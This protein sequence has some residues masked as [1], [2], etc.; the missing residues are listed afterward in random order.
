MQRLYYHETE[1]ALYFS[2]EAK[3]LLQAIP[4]LRQ[5]NPDSLAKHIT[6]DCVLGDKSLFKGISLLP[7][8]SCWTFGR[9]SRERTEKYFK[10]ESLESAPVIRHEDVVDQLERTFVDILP[11]YLEASERVAISLTGGL[12][13]R[14]IVAAAPDIRA[15]PA[16][17]FAGNRDTFDVR[18]SRRVAE[19]AGLNYEVI[20]L[21]TDF[22]DQ[23]PRLAEETIYISDGTFGVGGAHNLYL[24]R[25]ARKV[26]P[27]RLTGLF[28]SE[29]VRQGRIFSPAT[30]V[31]ALFDDGFLSTI[32]P[33][34]GRAIT[35]R[36]GHPL[37]AALFRD[38]PWRGHGSMSIERSQ[39]TLRSPFTDNDLTQLMYAIPGV[40][41]QS[42]RVQQRLIENRSREI[43]RILSNRGLASGRNPL[44]L[45]V[46]QTA[47]QVLFKADY[48]YFFDT[49]GWMLKSEPAIRLLKLPQLLL[50]Y[51]KFEHYRVWYRDNLS[52]YL[53]DTLLD[54]RTL[55]RPFFSRSG[56]RKA[57]DNHIAGKGNHRIELDVALSLELTMRTMIERN[58][59]VPQ[60]R[61][62]ELISQ[63]V[64]AAGLGTNR[65]A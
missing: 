55:E 16:Y 49:P 5:I 42:A 41:R 34:E 57:V 48:W 61:I 35:H 36:Q 39:V 50:G 43:A 46:V 18:Q 4:S 14:L 6:L 65:G 25:L 7:S 23:F 8:G 29:V 56:L 60:A 52:D 26:A 47:L 2:S 37:T 53:V 64:P 32:P 62:D 9:G 59:P 3:S 63:T 11:R 28:G 19:K 33:A 10:P 51:H 22:F 1:R 17:T 24:N 21:G 54:Q 27:V 38:I 12:D 20:R 13:T 40:A 31:N 45:W 30:R 15:F 58:V 44:A